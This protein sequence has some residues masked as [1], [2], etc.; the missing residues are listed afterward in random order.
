MRVGILV[1][2]VVATLTACGGEPD[3]QRPVVELA[4]STPGR[5]DE[6]VPEPPAN[7]R[8]EAPSPAPL[9]CG[10][11]DASGWARGTSCAPEGPGEILCSD[12][13]LAGWVYACADIDGAHAAPMKGCVDYGPHGS[14]PSWHLTLCPRP[15]CVRLE[16]ESDGCGGDEV[17]V[18]CPKP[19][20]AP[21]VSPPDA[22]CR[23]LRSWGDGRSSGPLF[24]CPR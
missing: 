3:V 4:A 7:A 1:V 10:V 22:R 13:P 8:P 19:R 24:C 15:M 2:V 20:F 23:E 18:A 5:G 11:T 17:A 16:L 14:T 12:P 21:D 9:A 6:A